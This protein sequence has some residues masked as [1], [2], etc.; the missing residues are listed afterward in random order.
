MLQRQTIRILQLQQPKLFE[1]VKK[2]PIGGFFYGIFFDMTQSITT[3]VAALLQDLSGKFLI[4]QRPADKMMPFL[5]EFP[6]G[7]LEDGES[8]EDALV[9][10][11]YEEIGIIVSAS[12]LKPFTFASM[13]YPDFH[14]ILLAYLCREWTGIPGAREGQGGL[15]WV[16]PE[17]LSKYPMP[18]AN[19]SL[20]PLLQANQQK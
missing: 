6:G 7:K 11:L 18:T 3:V 20:I 9:R 8:P 16:M 5:W 13:A 10:E 19:Q 17:N 4:A 14:I 2:P 12:S 15:E 1:Q